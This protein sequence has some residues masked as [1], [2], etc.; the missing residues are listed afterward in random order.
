MEIFSSKAC[1]DKEWCNKNIVGT[2]P[3]EMLEYRDNERVIGVAVDNHWLETAQFSRII[4]LEVPEAAT[5]RAMMLTGEADVG[6]LSEP[7]QADLLKRGYRAAD[8]H[9]WSERVTSFAGNFWELTNAQDGTALTPWATLPFE[10]DL[11]WIG[12]PSDWDLQYTDTDNPA[13]MDDMEQARLFRHALSMAID[14]DLIN[15]QLFSGLG[16]PYYINMFNPTDPNFQDKWVVNYDP[17]KAAELLDQAGYPEGANGVRL[18]VEMLTSP[19]QNEEVQEAVGGFWDDIGIKTT[20]I[21][22]PYGTFRPTLVD[23]T[24]NKITTHGCRHNNGLPWDWPRGA[25]ATSLTRGGFGCS[26]DRPFVIEAFQA[27]N[28]EDDTAERIAINSA[29]ADQMHKWMPYAGLVA[30]PKQVIYNPKSIAK[31][32]M[33]DCF[34][35]M[36]SA[37]AR[38]VPASR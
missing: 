7:D 23:R 27:T 35:C 26:Q 5:R 38:I 30:I 13:G 15:E 17:R 4:F 29:M 12:A 20:M 33:R 11:P 18:E 2:G 32:E 9:G 28:L 37:Q 16:I 6:V 22:N 1:E 14:R 34:E 19:G 10:K 8:A 21:V 3:F 24:V 36:H 31:W 25:Q